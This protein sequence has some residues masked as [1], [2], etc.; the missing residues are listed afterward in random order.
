MN[1]PSS[2]YQY[3]AL[4]EHDSIRLLVLEPSP[5][6][7]AEL[8][9]HLIATTIRECEANIYT[10]YIAISY[11]WGDPTPAASILLDGDKPFPLTASLDAALRGVRDASAVCRVWADALCI[12]QADIAERNRQVRL[13]GSIYSL[14]DHTVIYLGPLT[15]G[16]EW[17]LRNADAKVD[18]GRWPSP[19]S[20]EEEEE[21][22]KEREKNKSLRS[23]RDILNRPWFTRTW[24][25]QELVLS[26]DPL[27]QCGRLRTR[28]TRLY[29][30]FS[31]VAAWPAGDLAIRVPLG[32]E[33]TRLQFQQRDTTLLGLLSARRGVAATDPRDVVYA[34][35]GMLGER[36][37]ADLPEN[38][39]DYSLSVEQ[40][41]IRTARYILESGL[42]L[43]SPGDTFRE[44][45][46]W[47]SLQMLLSAVEDAAPMHNRPRSLPSWVPDWTLAKDMQPLRATYRGATMYP[48]SR[49]DPED[50]YPLVHDVRSWCAFVDDPPILVCLGRPPLY[51]VRAISPVFPPPSSVRPE[52]LHRCRE[53]LLSLLKSGGWK[54]GG[55]L[56]Q[57]QHFSV[58]LFSLC[59]AIQAL[60]AAQQ[61]EDGDTEPHFSKYL[62]KAMVSVLSKWID[63]HDRRFLQNDP[64]LQMVRA[65]VD[66][67]GAASPLQGRCLA[68]L[69]DRGEAIGVVPCHS[70]LGDRCVPL[71][72]SLSLYV[73]R[74]LDTWDPEWEQ[75]I[76]QK[77]QSLKAWEQAGPKE[78]DHST[79]RHAKPISV[80]YLGRLIGE[81][82]ATTCDQPETDSEMSDRLLLRSNHVVAIM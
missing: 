21:E 34:L 27:V 38:F 22:E 44:Q 55:V 59:S 13:M 74:H 14:A 70:R 37:A 19:P 62:R 48:G 42:G 66:G 7:E 40:V 56:G 61:P 28:W 49:H 12:N 6:P 30:L 60:P 47:K 4:P 18:A 65:Y 25:L 79:L 67:K 43:K 71:L 75:L 10:G 36:A 45:Q 41:Y 80:G 23:L 15:P 2:A 63:R 57:A 69:R 5:T 53:T 16:A 3:E 33:T 39:V 58:A 17:V 8:R 68:L 78:W 52:L 64:F 31:R 76:L 26:R 81:C 54:A 77:A 72:P 50:V 29:A 46:G 35:L 20:G 24:I 73:V 82:Y 32:M 1:E 11:V 9:G 51:I